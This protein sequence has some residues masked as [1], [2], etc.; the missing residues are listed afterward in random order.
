MGLVGGLGLACLFAA[1]CGGSTGSDQAA[2]EAD[3]RAQLSRVSTM[4]F[5]A[6]SSISSNPAP[7]LEL[8]TLDPQAQDIASA[9][10]DLP[11]MPPGTYNCPADFGVSYFLVFTG[12]DPTGVGETVMIATLDPAGCQ[13]GQISA[14]GQ[15]VYHFWTATSPDFWSRLAGDLG[16]AEAAIYPYTPPAP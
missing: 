1:G 7:T 6:T 14:D 4:T 16:V 11:Q 15:R 8:L 12:G 5:N 9:I 10:L 3:L 13:A 2:I